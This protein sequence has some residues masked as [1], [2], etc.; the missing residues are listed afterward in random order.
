[1]VRMDQAPD[2]TVPVLKVVKVRMD[3]APMDQ[4]PMVRALDRMADATALALTA[5]VPVLKGQRSSGGL[6]NTLVSQK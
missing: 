5:L 2:P 6:L 1:M 4:A 3:Q